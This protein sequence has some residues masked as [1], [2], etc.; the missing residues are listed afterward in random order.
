MNAAPKIFLL[1]DYHAETRYLLAKTLLRKFPDAIIR[2]CDE[3]E[4]A[5]DIVQKDN[6]SAIVCHRTF[7]VTNLEMVRELRDADSAV[8]I[9]M[10][11]GIDRETAGISAGATAFLSLGEWLRIGT[12][13]EQ[14]L[15]PRGEKDVDGNRVA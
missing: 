5:K 9:I 10:V 6:L 8:P 2:E 13:V 7:D 11:S 1:V 4:V 15:A 14:H 12:V 3:L